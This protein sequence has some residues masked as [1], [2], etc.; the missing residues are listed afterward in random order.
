MT[1]MIRI[2]C[3]MALLAA[4]PAL[5]KSWI[6]ILR[7]RRG[8]HLDPEIALANLFGRSSFND[9]LNGNVP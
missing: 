1:T 5:A 4:T 7:F 6:S 2:A 9:F 3:A 8:W